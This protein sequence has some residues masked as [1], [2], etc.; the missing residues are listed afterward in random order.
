[1]THDGLN[2][3]RQG[4][5]DGAGCM[6]TNNGQK[7][8]CK[9]A[10]RPP[11]ERGGDSGQRLRGG[12][13]RSSIASSRMSRMGA[14][15]RWSPVASFALSPSRVSRL[16]CKLRERAE[17]HE[18]PIKTEPLKRN[19]R[20]RTH[21]RRGGQVCLTTCSLLGMGM[22]RAG[23]F[24]LAPCYAATTEINTQNN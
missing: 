2:D 20:R 21:E 11:P 7:W 8:Q 16:L 1:M 18:A 3:G 13:A 9:T 17:G 10:T 19:P 6:Q 15:G 22:D 24:G 23:V 5:R 4:T 12:T 14:R